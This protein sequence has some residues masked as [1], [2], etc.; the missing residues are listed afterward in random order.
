MPLY[1]YVAVDSTGKKKRG[2]IDAD[3]PRAARTRLKKDHLFP[4]TLYEATASQFRLHMD[5]SKA[6]GTRRVRPQELTLATRQLATLVTAGLPLV[7][8]LSALT[9]QTDNS[10]L[11]RILVQVR[12]SVEEGKSLAKSLSAF[13]QVF[14][15]LYINLVHAG[16][17]SGTLD[18]VLTKLSE[19]LESQMKLR[20]K[21]RSALT[22]PAVMLIICMFVII[23]LVVGVIPKIVEI[24]IKQGA[25]LPLPT[26]ILIF[27]SDALINY[28]YLLLLIILGI[29]YG[30]VRFYRSPHGR[31]R[32]DRFLLHAPIFGPI[33]VKVIT[34]RFS[35]TLGTLVASGVGLLQSLDISKNVVGNVHAVRT[36]DNAREGV[37]EGKGL[38]AE[39]ARGKVFPSMLSRMIAVGEQSGSLEQMLEKASSTYE[40][41]VEASLEGLTSLLEP[42]LMVVVGGVVL[43]IVIA[44]LLPMADLINLVGSVR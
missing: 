6:L 31:E 10:S 41:D 21:V 42:L 16:E 12:E 34:A 3:S 38:A 28:W 39:L 25:T 17:T 43:C 37:R 44:V 19:Y 15:R 11:R 32:V 36:V 7:S 40:D 8:A 1:E 29:T 30:L 24:F 35:G 13:P 22:Y 20:R 27:I 26:R 33:Y 5:L 18:I 4:T 23:G 9:E 2:T 14:P